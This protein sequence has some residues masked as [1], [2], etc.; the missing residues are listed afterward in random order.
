MIKPTETPREI[1]AVLDCSALQSY[2]LG[3]VHIGELLIDIADEGADMAIP[4]VTLAEANGFLIQDAHAR[5]LLGLLVTLPGTVVL[6]LDAATARDMAPTAVQAHGDLS[7][8]HAV[9]AANRHGALYLTTE[10][11]TV[12][13]LIPPD[14]VHL[15]PAKD[16]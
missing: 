8:A 1:R 15:I 16:A 11:D 6:P 4:A 5:A 9:W 7:R 10:P 12:V 2:A 13:A 14:N 3:H